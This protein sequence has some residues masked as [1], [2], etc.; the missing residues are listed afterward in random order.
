MAFRDRN[1]TA[2]ESAISAGRVSLCCALCAWGSRYSMRGP[3]GSY[4]GFAPTC[5]MRGRQ[6]D[7][8]K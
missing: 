4:A 1:R 3:S 5:S 2:V 6:F 7:P 8:R